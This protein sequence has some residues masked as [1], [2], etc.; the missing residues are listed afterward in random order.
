M[1]GLEDYAYETFNAE[2]HCRTP[3]QAHHVGFYV[4]GIQCT[5]CSKVDKKKVSYS[6]SCS[7]NKRIRTLVDCIMV[8]NESLFI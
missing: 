2:K 3:F 6:L 4:R 5:E 1:L 7:L 8:F